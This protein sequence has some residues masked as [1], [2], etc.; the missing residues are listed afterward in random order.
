MSIALVHPG[1]FEN[2][3]AVSV[4]C[5]LVSGFAAFMLLLG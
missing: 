2:L 1:R 4:A 5:A 3:T